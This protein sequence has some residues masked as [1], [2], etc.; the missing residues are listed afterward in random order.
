MKCYFILFRLV[1]GL[2]SLFLTFEVS[3]DSEKVK[4]IVEEKISSLILQEHMEEC[5]Q[6]NLKTIFILFIK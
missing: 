5:R 2:L 3:K 6:N 1:W 4:E